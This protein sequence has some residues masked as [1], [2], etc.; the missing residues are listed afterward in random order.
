MP[1]VMEGL[2]LHFLKV[3]RVPFFEVKGHLKVAKEERK[4]GRKK[5]SKSESP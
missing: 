2:V 5:E 4:K 3:V 1:R